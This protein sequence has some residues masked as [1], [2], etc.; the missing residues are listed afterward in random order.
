MLRL[1]RKRKVRRRIVRMRRNRGRLLVNDGVA[2]AA[3]LARLVE[4][5]G[6]DYGLLDQPEYGI[7]PAEVA[8]LATELEVSSVQAFQ[9]LVQEVG[10]ELL[11][12]S[13]AVAA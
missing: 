9:Y 11:R 13:F 1:H 5:Y 6:R 10:A 7:L 12:E 4:H 3:W 8:A 2:A